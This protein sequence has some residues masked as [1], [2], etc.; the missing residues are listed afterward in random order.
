MLPALGLVLGAT[1]AMAMNVPTVVA[2]RTATKIWTP[3][4]S[5]PN[6]H[7][8]VT[9]IVQSQDYECNASTMDCL[10]EFSND[11]PASGTR[12]VLSEGQFVEL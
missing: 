11:D 4:S 1:M 2:E 8:D 12:N 7:R 10:V 5:Q 6:G 9:S 3:D